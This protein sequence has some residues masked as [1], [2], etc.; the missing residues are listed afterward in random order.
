MRA[1]LRGLPNDLGV[2]RDDAGVLVVLPEL[3]QVVARDVALVA[4]RDEPRQRPCESSAARRRTDAP[5]EPDCIEI[6]TRAG[7][8]VDAGTSAA[9]TPTAR[10]DAATPMLPGPMMRMPWRR[11]RAT[12][13]ST[14]T[15]VPSIDGDD[16]RAADPLASM[17]SSIVATP[18]P[19][20]GRRRWPAGRRRGCPAPRRS[21]VGRRPSRGGVDREHRALG[22]ARVTCVHSA[23]PTVPGR[24][25]RADHGDRARQQ[26]PGD[27]PAVGALLA[28]LDG[29]EE[30][31]GVLERRSRG[32]RHRCRSAAGPASP[33]GEHG[34]H[35]P[36][37]GQ[38]LGGEADDA[39][40]PGDG[41]EVLEQQG[42][43]ALALVAVV[44][45]ERDVGV[46][47]AGPPL[48]AGPGDELAVA[49]DHEGDAVD[50]VDVREVLQVGVAERRLRREEAPV[51]ALVG[52]A[53]VERGER[54]GVVGADRAHE[55]ALAVA[56][57]DR[58]RPA[59]GG[60][61][62][63]AR[64]WGGGH[65]TDDATTCAADARPRL[66]VDHDRLQRVNRRQS[67]DGPVTSHSTRSS[68]PSAATRPR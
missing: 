53:A 8:Q 54:R 42:G 38:H 3:Q 34:E 24:S 59:L 16:H 39:V 37:V 1:N 13:A 11:A 15:S 17:Q 41:G 56:E 49:L 58:A 27:R 44:D 61:G 46:V 62:R 21:A 63:V 32:R 19:R 12:S 51:D 55:H 66:V 43:D 68:S 65:G 31:V 40:G 26:Q 57:H 48:V 10:G 6:A 45:L 50:H 60:I 18:A 33:P 23:S 64:H 35:R 29:V 52:L 22:E 25:R 30:L 4:E 9:L 28:P 14:S 47:A 20:P 5:S 2:H 67:L 36:V 7:W